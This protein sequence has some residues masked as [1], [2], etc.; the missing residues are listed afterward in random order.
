MPRP[1]PVS[2][3]AKDYNTFLAYRV[4]DGH[5]DLETVSQPAMQD[6]KRAQWHVSDLEADTWRFKIKDDV[7]Y[8]RF[9]DI[10]YADFAIRS[11]RR[12]HRLRDL[13]RIPPKLRFQVPLPPP[14]S[15]VSILE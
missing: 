2:C 14:H 8:P 12:F 7:K 3:T 1:G 15:A 4:L 10:G 11:Y 13:G 6:G 9:G 5:P